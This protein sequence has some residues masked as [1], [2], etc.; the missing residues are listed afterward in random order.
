VFYNSLHDYALE[1][2]GPTI[3]L[4]WN[5]QDSKLKSL[6]ISRLVG[7]FGDSF[8]KPEV[9]KRTGKHLKHVREAY[10]NKLVQDP[11][12]ECPL[13]V[14]E[15]EWKEII[16]DARELGMKAQGKKPPGPGR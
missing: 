16:L 3:R 11:K 14:P 6:L 8:N 10:R 1:L 5:R 4:R 9:L 12:C 15:R 2:F 13:V 7:E